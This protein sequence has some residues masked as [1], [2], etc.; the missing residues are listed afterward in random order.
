MS[1]INEI[2]QQIKKLPAGEPFSAVTFQSLGY[3]E[4]IRKILTRLVNAAE[5]TRVLPG[6]F[7]KPKKVAGLG[8]VLPEPGK[9]L[10][11]IA[12]STGEQMG[13]HGAEAARRLKLTTQVPLKRVLYTSGTSR[14]I[15]LGETEIT[16][17]H[18]SPKKLQAEGTKAGLVTSALW[19]LGS[20]NINETVIK[21]IRAQ[22]TDSEFK[23]LLEDT[24]YMPAWMVKNLR[25]FG[26]NKGQK[27][28][29]KLF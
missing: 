11:V 7:V 9:V 19:Y 1:V 10:N 6:V 22:L 26:D 28:G 8:E 4:N 18:V 17:K 3:P 15:K 21:T 27:N 16:L 23:S 2:R 5:I 14:K 25:Q 20:K 24:Q 29:N 12:K 13:I